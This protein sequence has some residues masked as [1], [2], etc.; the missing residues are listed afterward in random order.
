MTK[1]HPSVWMSQNRLQLGALVTCVFCFLFVFYYHLTSSSER[2]EIIETKFN[3][4]EN[5]YFLSEDS[6]IPYYSRIH[7]KNGKSVEF[8]WPHYENPIHGILFLFHRCSRNGN[9]W[10]LLPEEVN[11]VQ[12][13][14]ELGLLPIAFSSSERKNTKCW[15]TNFPIRMPDHKYKNRDLSIIANTLHF[16]IYE[17]NWMELPLHLLGVS[18]GAIL[19]SM[20][21][22]QLEYI[23]FSSL[24]LYIPAEELQVRSY[25]FI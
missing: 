1:Q 14:L 11:F 25:V 19:A 21:P 24:M 15:D 4:M 10:F 16:L 7:V 5:N 13:A 20:I 17:N 18:D 8:F 9:H 2:N 6:P 12:K 22:K 3:I 23:E